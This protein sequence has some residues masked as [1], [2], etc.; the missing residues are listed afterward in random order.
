MLLFRGCDFGEGS[1]VCLLVE[2]RVTPRVLGVHLHLVVRKE[3][4]SE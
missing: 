1:D 4:V 2:T 3:L